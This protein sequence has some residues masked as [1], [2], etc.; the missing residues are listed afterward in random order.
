MVRFEVLKSEQIKFGRNKFLEVA[1]K[2]AIT[3]AGENEFISLSK[4]FFTRSGEKRYKS[5]FAIPLNKDVATFVSQK[6]LEML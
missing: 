1:R 3:Q 2:K 6:I 4:G 5:N